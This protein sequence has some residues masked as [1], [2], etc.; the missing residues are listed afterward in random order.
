MSTVLLVEDDDRLR[1]AMAILL[2]SQGNHVLEAGTVTEGRSALSDRILDCA[3]IDLGLPDGSGIELI[4]AIRGQHPLVPI[5]VLSARREATD[6]VTALDAG[7]DDYVTKPFGV[8]E[9]LAR[10]RAALRRSSAGSS[11]SSLRLGDTRI[12]LTARSAVSGE[13]LDIRLTPTEWAVLECLARARGRAVDSAALLADVW[14]ERGVNQPHYLRVYLAQ[15]RQKLEPEPGNPRYLVTVPGSGYRLSAA[16]QP[17]DPS[18]SSLA[19]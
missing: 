17:P 5:I 1:R 18:S 15:L 19:P 6:K 13:G 2:R 16:G 7:A 9:L 11:G 3:V 8:D 10:I 12:D 14:G 4:S